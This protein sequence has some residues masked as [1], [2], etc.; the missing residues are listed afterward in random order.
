MP[1]CEA[2]FAPTRNWSLCR[3]A[4]GW[5]RAC[6]PWRRRRAAV[7]VSLFVGQQALGELIGVTRKTVNGILAAFER[8]GLV[9]LGYGRLELLDLRGLEAA[10]NS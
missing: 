1:R 4:S 2:S 10:A 6:S 9:E 5:R 8:E 7:P 3:R